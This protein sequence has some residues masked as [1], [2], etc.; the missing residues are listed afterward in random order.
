MKRNSRRRI[1]EEQSCQTVGARACSDAMRGPTVNARE[2]ATCLSP[3]KLLIA[4]ETN[5][6]G[7]VGH[8]RDPGNFVPRHC[9]GSND[10]SPTTLRAK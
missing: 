5:K 2:D 10:P 4:V 6:G 1:V 9:M 7:Q 3:V 8:G